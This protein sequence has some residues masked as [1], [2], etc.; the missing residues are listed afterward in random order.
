M[1]KIEYLP[2]LH[3]NILER[4]VEMEIKKESGAPLYLQLIEILND[5]IESEEIRSGEKIPSERELSEIY[6][7]S[8]ATVRQ[9]L[10][11][12]QRQGII[13]KIQGKGNFVSQKRI[14]QELNGFYSFGDEVQK[15]GKKPGN[16]VLS[17][18]LKESGQAVGKKMGISNEEKVLVLSRIRLADGE[19][20]MNEITYLP[21]ERF[22]GL[23]ESDLEEDG[24]Y[25][26]MKKKYG[27]KFSYAEESFYPCILNDVEAD[28]LNVPSG[29][30]GIVLERY[31]Y[32]GNKLIEY[33]KSI[34][35]G[36]KFK[37]K[38]K[39]DIR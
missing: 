10:S 26:I 21:F 27:V 15:Q 22:I 6:S 37:Y 23:E 25:Q 24:L 19:A 38:V 4:E 3:Y 33:T 18:V 5:R 28:I 11:E 9:A 31:T 12:L 35:R 36:D 34:V 20:M 32:E 39:L 14:N 13:Y 1:R 8:R 29:S 30:P 17:L 16:R 2:H 7:I